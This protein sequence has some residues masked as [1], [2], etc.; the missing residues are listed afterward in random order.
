VKYLQVISSLDPANGGPPESVRLLSEATLALGH[1]VELATMDDPAR[2]FS[3]TFPCPVH[4]LGPSRLGTYGFC[5]ALLQ[6]LHTHVARYDAVIVNGLWQYHGAAVRLAA[7]R[8]QRPYFVFPHGMLDPWFRLRYPLRHAK[9]LLYWHLAERRVLADARAVLF[10]CEEERR[11][12]RATFPQYQA[13]EAIVCLGTATPPTDAEASRDKFLARHPEL[14]DKDFLLFMG[15]IHPKKGIDMLLR[16]LAGCDTATRPVLV[17][18][19]PDQNGQRQQLERLAQDLAVENVV[20]TGMLTGPLK[21]GALHSAAAFV[22]PSHQENFGIAVAEA[23]AC[24]LP[25]LISN[26]VNIWR[27]IA[28]DEAGLVQ[29]DTV[30]GTLNLIR[31]WISLDA[32]TRARMASNAGACFAR[33]FRIDSA[34]AALCSAINSRLAAAHPAAA[35]LG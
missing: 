6:W 16:A 26:K 22:L 34:A 11:L 15:R 33:R 27:E 30:E 28:M 3:Q 21:W 29:D 4:E 8:A 25:S 17:I 32:P 35:G 19:G 24:G 1:T 23:L 18:A 14:R 2:G 31:S 12:A 9:K 10:T 7:R 5:P 13:A 20:W